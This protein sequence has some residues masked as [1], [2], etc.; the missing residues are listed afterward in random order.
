MT[1]EGFF[2][3]LRAVSLHCDILQQP[4]SQKHQLGMLGR[5]IVL[6]MALTGYPSLCNDD[7]K[8]PGELGL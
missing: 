4:G 1:E 3:I 2:S 5:P 6:G 8:R 7:A